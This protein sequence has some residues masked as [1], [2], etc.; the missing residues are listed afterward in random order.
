MLIHDVTME[1]GSTRQL[2]QIRRIRI[3]AQM[4]DPADPET[5]YKIPIKQ[6]TAVREF[7]MSWSNYIDP[8]KRFYVTSIHADHTA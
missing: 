3:I 8:L 4:V 6:R 5:K 2:A 1:D 7:R